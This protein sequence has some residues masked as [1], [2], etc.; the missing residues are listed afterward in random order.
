MN[1]RKKSLSSVWREQHTTLSVLK[2]SSSEL[3]KAFSDVAPH[4]HLLLSLFP[5]ISLSLDSKQCLIGVTNF[6]NF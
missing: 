3:L 2:G 5:V 1:G 4:T 6:S